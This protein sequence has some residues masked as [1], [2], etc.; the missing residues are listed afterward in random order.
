MS[1]AIL[2]DRDQV[3]RLN[4]IADR[5]KRLRG[6]ELLWVDVDRGSEEDVDRV[7]DAFGLD[8]ETREP[9]SRPRRIERSSATTAAT[10]MSR[11]MRRTKTT[12]GS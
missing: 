9:A 6:S 12:K 4:D 8:R 5:P 11:P 3:E 2:F 7:A 10:S 1:E